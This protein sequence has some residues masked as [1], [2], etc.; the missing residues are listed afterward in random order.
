[1]FSKSPPAPPEHPSTVSP[2]KPQEGGGGAGL[3][4][5][6]NHTFYHPICSPS[7][8]KVEPPC[9]PCPETPPPSPQSAAFP[10]GSPKPLTGGIF[11][12]LKPEI[13]VCFFLARPP[14]PPPE[15]VGT[16]ALEPLGEAAPFA[17]PPVRTAE[18][19][20]P[21]LFSLCTPTK[22]L[23]LPPESRFWGTRT[24]PLPFPI[25]FFLPTILRSPP[26]SGG[27]PLFF[28]SPPAR[29][30]ALVFGPPPPIFPP[31]AP[32]TLPA[33]LGPRCRLFDIRP[34]SISFRPPV[35]FVMPSSFFLLATPGPG[36]KP[37]E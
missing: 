32:S 13:P 28:G 20:R 36:L 5:T 19:P 29:L 4:Q 8:A 25:F 35:L 21:K 18:G 14:R 23:G 6:L 34:L 37:P 7:P 3:P 15:V 9:L 16:K 33:I 12:G 11:P 30:M 26:P 22:N 24:P 17:P 27:P 10:I 1:L 31:V 2:G